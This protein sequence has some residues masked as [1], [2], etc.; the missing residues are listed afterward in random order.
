MDAPVADGAVGEVHELPEA[1]WM[2]CFVVWAVRGRPAPGVPIEA[3]RGFAIGCLDAGAACAADEGSDHA[4]FS[5]FA[6]LEKFH[7]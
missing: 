6:A 3:R 2:N 1:S 5:H 4:D 7:A